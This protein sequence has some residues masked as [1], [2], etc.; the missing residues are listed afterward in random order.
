M[1][2]DPHTITYT[3]NGIRQGVAFSVPKNILNGQAL[4]PHIL[5]KNQNFTVNFGQ[6]PAP[7]K[8]LLPNFIPIGQLDLKDGLVRGP[9]APLSRQKCE[10]LLMIGLPGAGK[11]FWA[12]KYSREN[13]NKRYN[14]LGT[15]NLIDRKLN[16][17]IT[18]SGYWTTNTIIVT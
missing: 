15:N 7:L 6:L 10:V 5:T 14:I 11:T 18:N 3:V 2:C 12:E 17:S 8:Q 16:E 9:L 1:T 4:F 13:P